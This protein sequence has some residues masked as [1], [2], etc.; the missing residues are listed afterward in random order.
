[1]RIIPTRFACK[2]SD[3]SLNRVRPFSVSDDALDAWQNTHS[4]V[5]SLDET[6]DRTA[7]TKALHKNVRGEATASATTAGVDTTTSPSSHRELSSQCGP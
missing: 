5:S 3:L 2:L 7:S 4:L 1:M 6:S